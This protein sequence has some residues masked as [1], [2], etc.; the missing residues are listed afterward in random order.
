ML[1]FKQT[2]FRRCFES[3]RK[4]RAAVTAWRSH[5]ESLT[6]EPGA[7]VAVAER[8]CGQRPRA[9][10]AAALRSRDLRS[11]ERKKPGRRALW[12]SDLGTYT[13]RVIHVSC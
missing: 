1:F 13:E 6:A 8:G 5:R 9:P 12:P 4:A 3:A 10:P 7:R 11:L 2:S